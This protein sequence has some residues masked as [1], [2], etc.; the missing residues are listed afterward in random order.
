MI[1]KYE[2]QPSTVMAEKVNRRLLARHGQLM[3]VEFSFAKGAVAAMH[4]HPHEQVGYIVKGCLELEISGKKERL[5]PGDSYYVAPDTM[6][7][8]VALQDTII[9]DVFTPQREDF[10]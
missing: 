6:H 5:Q 8:A 2:A 3:I 4:S 10:L 9:V 1:F 7:G